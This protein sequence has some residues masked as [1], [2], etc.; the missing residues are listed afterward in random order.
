MDRKKK[1]VTGELW[2]DGCTNL[3]VKAGND[4]WPCAISKLPEGMTEYDTVTANISSGK[5]SAIVSAKRAERI[6]R[7]SGF[8]PPDGIRVGKVTQYVDGKGIIDFE[9]GFDRAMVKALPNAEVKHGEIIE[10]AMDDKHSV[11]SVTGPFGTHVSSWGQ[12]LS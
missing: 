7:P 12:K 8:K 1:T 11:V 10:Y 4:W 9:Y 2:R 6:L 3:F 5:V